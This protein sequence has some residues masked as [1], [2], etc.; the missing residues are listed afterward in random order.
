MII[1]NGLVFTGTEFKQKDL[2]TDGA[3]IADSCSC[4]AIDTSTTSEFGNEIIDATDLYVCP[5]L[6][7]IHTHGGGGGDFMDATEESFDKVL[8]ASLAAK[9]VA[10]S[11]SLEKF[12]NSLGLTPIFCTICPKPLPSA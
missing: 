6:V 5:G 7:D 2:Y 3:V 4:S 9:V 11:R 10:S 12:L 1:K 8:Y